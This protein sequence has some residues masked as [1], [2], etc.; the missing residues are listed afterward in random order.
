M[1]VELVTS[2][3]L[4]GRGVGSVKVDG[5]LATIDNRV[6]TELTAAEEAQLHRLPIIRK[7]RPH[8]PKPDAVQFVLTID[9]ERQQRPRTPWADS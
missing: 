9:G 6:T 5:T 7:A 2:G 3:G 1:H 4:T 8:A